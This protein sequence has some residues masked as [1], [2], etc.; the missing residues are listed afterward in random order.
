MKKQ[1]VQSP[2]SGVKMASLLYFSLPENLR[3]K[4]SEFLTTEDL[5]RLLSARKLDDSPG[6]FS[7]ISNT[8][9]KVG[10]KKNISF[11]DILSF[12][13]LFFH[14]VYISFALF[15]ESFYSAGGALLYGIGGFIFLQKESNAYLRL[16]FFPFPF[17]IRHFALTVLAY[18]VILIPLGL[19][20][21]GAPSISD[22]KMLLI[23]AVIL[24]P[25]FEEIFFRDVLFKVFKDFTK[26]DFAIILITAFLFSIVHLSMSYGLGDMTNAFILYFSAGLI[27]GAI[28]W[29]SCSLLYPILLHVAVNT[30]VFYL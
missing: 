3:K 20:T 21:A 4:L 16:R 12:L 25:L 15:F 9:L 10:T 8:I 22:N 6:I 13:H 18:P 24:A 26:S 11:K 23:Q 7:H 30:T 29:I 17:Q 19:Y 27:L 2:F 1:V 14:L 28:R 5:G